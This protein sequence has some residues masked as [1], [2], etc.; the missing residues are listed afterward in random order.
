MKNFTILTIFIFL[1]NACVPQITGTVEPT[2]TDAG[3]IAT[4]GDLAVVNY[5]NASVMLLDS[6]GNFKR[7]LY[8]AD[9]AQETVYGIGW[10]ADSKEI[11]VTVNNAT[12]ANG[13][14]IIA[15]S[16]VDATVRTF[17]TDHLPTTSLKGVAQLASGEVIV[18]KGNNIEKYNTN[19]VRVTTGGW[20]KASMT[21]PEQLTATSTGGFVTCSATTDAI[22]TYNSSA[23]QINTVSNVGATNGY[24]C[25]ILSNGGVAGA[26]EGAG[27]EVVTYNSALGGATDIYSDSANML[28]TPRQII[29]KSNGNLLIA[30]TVRDWLV[31]I[32]ITGTFVTTLGGSVLND[33]Y[34]LIEIPSF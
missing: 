10:K 25:T 28:Q 15:I 7:I 13:V 6:T 29:Q 5:G 21:A 34:A 30:D 26:W 2:P 32:T 19:G 17:A 14:K 23:V 22:R 33:P 11:L 18:A 24:G 9:Q 3:Y 1:F 4:A 20:P 31:E 12:G 16:A 27:D 8:D